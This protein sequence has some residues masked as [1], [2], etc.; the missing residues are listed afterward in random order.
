MSVPDGLSKM[1]PVKGSVHRNY[2]VTFSAYIVVSGHAGS[3]G[4]MCPGFGI[5][6]PEISAVLHL[7]KMK[8]LQ[9]PQQLSEVELTAVDCVKYWTK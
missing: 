4:F 3:F 9:S 8:S 7:N 6:L 5:A 1:P 2:K